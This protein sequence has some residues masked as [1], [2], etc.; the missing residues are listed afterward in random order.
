MMAIPALP[1]SP[2]DQ[3]ES[4]SSSMPDSTGQP[5]AEPVAVTPPVAPAVL[6]NARNNRPTSGLRQPTK[7]TTKATAA[8]V[9]DSRLPSARTTSVFDRLYKTQTAASKAWMPVRSQARKAATPKRSGKKP[10]MDDTLKTF[11]RLHITGTVANTSKRIAAKHPVR[12]NTPERKKRSPG[13]NIPST[14]TPFRSP[15]RKSGASPAA[16]VYSPRMKPLTKLYFH[17]KY[18][19]GIGKETIDPIKLGYAFFQSF[20]EYEN[21]NTKSEQVAREIIVAFFKKDFPAGR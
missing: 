19:P 14:S 17:S 18:H 2:P 16:Y 5:T 11:H 13:K 15:V 6:Q 12:F 9:R 4:F 20:C 8:R 21:G 7:R 3:P 1:D 10:S